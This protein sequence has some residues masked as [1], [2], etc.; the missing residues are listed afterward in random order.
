MEIFWRI[1][2]ISMLEQLRI[3]FVHV[4]PIPHDFK[5]LLKPK[6]K[7]VKFNGFCESAS[8][9]KSDAKL[10]ARHIQSCSYIIARPQRSCCVKNHLRSELKDPKLLNINDTNSATNPWEIGEFCSLV[11]VKGASF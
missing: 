3:N 8:F 7:A 10:R 6:K 9:A 1:H 2:R 5:I 4:L 11:N